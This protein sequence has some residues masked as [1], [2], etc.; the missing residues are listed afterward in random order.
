MPRLL[1]RCSLPSEVER[2]AVAIAGQP[3]SRRWPHGRAAASADGVIIHHTP[4]HPGG[5]VIH[6]ISGKP[7]ARDCIMGVPHANHGS[8][9][10]TEALCCPRPVGVYWSRNSAP[11]YTSQEDRR[12]GRRWHCPDV[13]SGGIACRIREGHAAPTDIQAANAFSP[14][15]KSPSRTLQPREALMSPGRGRTMAP[16]NR[17]MEDGTRWDERSAWVSTT[18]VRL[19][20]QCVM[21]S[22]MNE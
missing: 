20:L 15:R 4:R 12:R 11:G 2:I 10:E 13:Q 8:Q 16:K 14:I 5:V 3:R 7:V 9:H 1:I 17:K 22:R 6:H 21:S 18:T 19:R